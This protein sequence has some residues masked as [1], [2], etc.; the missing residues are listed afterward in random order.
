MSRRR[1]HQSTSLAHL[2]G[3]VVTLKHPLH[4]VECWNTTDSSWADFAAGEPVKIAC[5][6]PDTTT[7]EWHGCF[8]GDEEGE[9]KGRPLRHPDGTP[10]PSPGYRFIV[11][12]ADLARAIGFYQNPAVSRAATQPHARCGRRVGCVEPVSEEEKCR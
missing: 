9:V 5:V 4:R 11:P 3:R 6:W 10:N 7:V 8:D 1:P 2:T 12:N